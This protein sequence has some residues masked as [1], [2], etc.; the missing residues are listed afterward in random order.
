VLAV[1]RG[2]FSVAL[3]GKVPK[4]ESAF[5]MQCCVFVEGLWEAFRVR[6]CHFL[7]FRSSSELLTFSLTFGCVRIFVLRT[8]KAGTWARF[9]G[10]LFNRSTSIV[11]ALRQMR[12]LFNTSAVGSGVSPPSQRLFPFSGSLSHGS[13][14]TLSPHRRSLLLSTHPLLQQSIVT[15]RLPRPVLLPEA[16]RGDCRLGTAVPRPSQLSLSGLPPARRPHCSLL[17]PVPATSRRLPLP[18]ARVEGPR[19]SLEHLVPSQT[20]A[21]QDSTHRRL[22]SHVS[23]TLPREEPARTRQEEG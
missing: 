5:C 11:Y 6:S 9:R 10:F 16:P 20:P 7:H 23:S 19:Q 3:F 15:S 13:R 2:S 22:G 12:S 4:R 1:Y 8:I 18:R 21:T 14:P 17:L